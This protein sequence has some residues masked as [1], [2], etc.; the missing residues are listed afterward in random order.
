[1]YKWVAAPY[2]CFHEAQTRFAHRPLINGE[3][4]PLSAGTLAFVSK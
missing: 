3:I 4:Y 1:M 2:M